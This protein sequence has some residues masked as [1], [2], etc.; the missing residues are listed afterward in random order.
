MADHGFNSDQMRVVDDT[1][2]LVDE[3]DEEIVKIAKSIEELAGIFK[4]LSAMVI[5]QGTVLDRIDY[6]ME[7][8]IDHTKD[9]MEQLKKAEDHQKNS[10]SIKCIILLCF[11][12]FLLVVV[13]IFKHQGK[14]K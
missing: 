6:N 4:E 13:L 12:I 2:A 5:D 7:Q 9:G 11:L 14:K 3:R 1:S 10:L 8:T